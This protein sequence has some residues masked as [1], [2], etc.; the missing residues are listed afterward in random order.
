MADTAEIKALLNKLNLGTSHAAAGDYVVGTLEAAAAVTPIADPAT[1]TA[2]DVA[3]KLNEL[4][5]ALNSQA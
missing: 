3:T 1:A 2:E 5:T 4:I